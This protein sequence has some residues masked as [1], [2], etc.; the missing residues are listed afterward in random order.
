MSSPV[1][2]T[3]TTSTATSANI[4]PNGATLEGLDHWLKDFQK[5]E[6]ILAEM[7]KASA[8]NK[9]R[10]ELATIEQWFKVLSES[11]RTASVYT[12]LQHSTQDQIR[13]FMAVL[14]K[15]IK[16]GESEIN[17]S[18]SAD[19][20]K[21]KN[22]KAG[23]RPPSLNIPLPGSPSTP[24]PTITSKAHDSA[25]ALLGESKRLNLPRSPLRQ[26]P[27]SPLVTQDGPLITPAHDKSWASLVNTPLVP[28]FQKPDPN[29]SD[30][31]GSGTTTSAGLGITQAGSTGN[32]G[33]GLAAINP[34]T[35]NMLA[36]SGLT[37]DAQLLAVQLVMSGI[38]QPTDITTTASK[39][40][41]AVPPQSAG[42]KKSGHGNWRAPS[43]AKY[44]GSALRSSAPKS[45]GVKSSGLKSSGL[46]SNGLDSASM[47]S[48][49]VEDFD[50]EL[51]KDIPAWLRSLRLHK[52]TA[53]FEGMTWQEMVALDDGVLEKKGVTALGARRR[54]LRTFDHVRRE[55]GM[56]GASSATPTTSVVPASAASS[57]VDPGLQI[58]PQSAAPRIQLSA[59]SPAFMP[60]SKVPHSAAPG[61]APIPVVTSV[62]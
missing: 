19:A 52:Y 10:D 11:E 36:T 3:L 27:L 16:P 40:D 44:P 55:M 42:K 9:F 41:Q 37:N 56:E 28:M 53:R 57:S 25:A 14:Q 54:L 5:Y 18:D 13:F 24:I 34:A 39:Q 59:D 7:A 30:V 23:L 17:A 35:L 61:L 15:M 33:P 43:S 60:T 8:D 22:S 51:L 49:R 38:L 47:E 6:A 4:P 26:T 29:R 2:A 46:K 12:L 21:P 31:S 1:A 45:S 62:V 58:V 48:P 50:P 32:K 20:T